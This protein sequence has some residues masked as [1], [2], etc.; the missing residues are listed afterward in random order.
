MEGDDR[1][2]ETRIGGIHALEQIGKEA[3]EY[4]WPVIEILA[5]YVRHRTPRTP[6]TD[7]DAH[8]ETRTTHREPDVQAA[9]SVIG[10]RT[11]RH[12]SEVARIDLEGTDLRNAEFSDANCTGI[13]FWRAD[14]R[15]ANFD[16]AHLGRAIL[17]EADLSNADLRDA[18]LDKAVLYGTNLAEALNLKQEQINQADGDKETELPDGLVTPKS[19]TIEE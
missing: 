18:K 3:E 1:R 11:R 13:W 5:A 16:G 17:Q 10:R 6:E 12:E 7:A 15:G 19:W 9:L 14:L 4:Y 2:V 8:D